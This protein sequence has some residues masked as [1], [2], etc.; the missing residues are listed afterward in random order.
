MANMNFLMLQLTTSLAL[1]VG[2][3]RPVSKQAIYSLQKLALTTK[4]RFIE[5]LS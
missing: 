1:Y 5:F 4:R 2:V 3:V